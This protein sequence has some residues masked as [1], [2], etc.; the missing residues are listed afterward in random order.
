M[1]PDLHTLQS[2][3]VLNT[4]GFQHRKGYFIIDSDNIMTEKQVVT[5]TQE[6]QFI[7]FGDGGHIR[8]RDVMFWHAVVKDNV[9]KIILWDIKNKM[10]VS[11]I[12]FLDKKDITYDWFL[13]SDEV[14]S[15]LM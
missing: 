10:I 5:V 1:R 7:E 3:N 2:P 4:N 15:D 8:V 13:I 12:L 6:Y 9:V 14:L 11:K